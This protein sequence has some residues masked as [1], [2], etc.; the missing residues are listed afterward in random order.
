MPSGLSGSRLTS[1]AVSRPVDDFVARRVLPEHRPVVALLRKL[2]R[3]HA[4]AARE[5]IAY[6]IPMW[7]AKGWVAFLSP[8][9]R[10]VTFGFAYGGEFTDRYGLLRGAG[11]KSKHVKLRSVDDVNVTALRSYLRQAMARDARS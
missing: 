3:D 4:P 2:M 9:K 5:Q 11:K 8:T 10:D 7:K 1:A 6:G